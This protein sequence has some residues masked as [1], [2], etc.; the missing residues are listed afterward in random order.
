MLKRSMY[1]V[2]IMVNLLFIIFIIIAGCSRDSDR[3]V[4][5]IGVILP[6]TGEMAKYG[7]TIQSAA[8]LAVEEI[9]KK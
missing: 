9:N 3:N 2:I 4:T 1:V 8:E 5:K 7:K 6:L